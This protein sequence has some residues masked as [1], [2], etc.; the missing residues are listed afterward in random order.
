LFGGHQAS[1]REAKKI[2]W[3]KGRELQLFP[4]LGGLSMFLFKKKRKK[5]DEI[6]LGAKR[7]LRHKEESVKVIRAINTIDELNNNPS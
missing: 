7:Y 4:S 5:P 1:C 2:G 3:V 6:E